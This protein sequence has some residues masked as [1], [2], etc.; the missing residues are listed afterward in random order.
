MGEE[1]DGMSI[2]ALSRATGISIHSIR[3]WERRYGAPRSIRRTSGHR[4]YPYEEVARLRAV[5]RAMTLGIRPSEVANLEIPQINELIESIRPD[6]VEMHPGDPQGSG[7][8][9]DRIHNWVMAA[10][11]FDDYLL[12]REFQD[13]WNLLGPI[14]FITR[15]AVPF[16]RELGDCWQTGCV[17][18][19]N[20]HF[21]S[22]KMS[23]FLSSRWRSL[24]K[25]A[26]YPP[27]IVTGV[28]KDRHRSSLHMIAVIAAAARHRVIFLG[29][30]TP[31]SNLVTAFEAA[32]ATGGVCLSISANVT[33]NSA[34]RFLNELAEKLP[35]DV[36]I[37]SGG[38]GAPESKGRTLRLETFLDLYHWLRKRQ[39][40]NLD[41]MNA[42]NAS[43]VCYLEE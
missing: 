32:H 7:A 13:G 8:A 29:S 3:M 19:A 1:Q 10:R 36:P 2:G 27:V 31:V 41:R 30:E 25:E 18:I 22:E 37:I 21:A 17:D 40:K 12:E 33:E 26:V 24:N 14:H 6:V 35:E 38:A 9:S 5:S 28:P 4:R 16:M 42:S 11:S 34:M 23:D 20:E 15:M 43:P 39:E